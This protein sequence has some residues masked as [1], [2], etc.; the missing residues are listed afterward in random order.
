[1]NNFSKPFSRRSLLSGASSLG[2]LYAAGGFR[3]P[4]PLLAQAL[5]NDPRIAAQPIADKGFASVRKIG[6]GLY[7]LISD[8]SKGLQTRSNGGFLIGR[9]A[10]LLVEGFQTTI[11]STFQLE[12]LRTVTQVPVRA[13]LN[14][15]WHFDHTLGNSVYGG[16]AIPI[17]AHANAALRMATY[18]P[19]WQ[20]QDLAA[21]IAPWEKRVRDAKTD[22]QREHAKSDVEGITGMFVPVSQAV[23][24]LPNHPLDPAKMPMEIDLGGLTVVIE[25]Y[26]GHTDT[27]LIF[28]VPDQNIIYTGDLLTGGQYPV[29][30]N[31]YPTKWRQTLA[32]FATFDKNT[33]FVPGHGQIMGLEGVAEM[34]SCFD[35][36]AEHAEKSYKTGVSV[37]EAIEEYVVPDKFKNYRMFSWGFTIG[38]TYEQFYAEWSGKPVNVLNYS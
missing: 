12:T 1:M 20:S 16:A 19:K 23:L 13:A 32:K 2:A 36:L 11:G 28:R 38:R 37:E 35:D 18:Y 22:S 5:P 4:V 25:T 17:W 10:A 8:R 24:A 14:T 29:N 21:Y 6:N 3:R 31:G 26:I 30:I 33:L 27:D 7:A 15:H 34:R 9:D